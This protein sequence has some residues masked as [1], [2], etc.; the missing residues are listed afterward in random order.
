MSEGFKIGRAQAGD[1]QRE[2]PLCIPETS[3]EELAAVAE[4]LKT[5]WL[6]HGPKNK[7]FERLFAEY[8]GVPYAVSLNSCAS[9]LFLVLKAAQIRG[10]VI[11]PSFTFV[12]SANAVEA[13][14][15]KCVFA[16]VDFE[17]CMLNPAAVAAAVTSR[18]EALMVVHF[19]GQLAD[20]DALTAIA[21]KHKLLLIEDSAEAIGATYK[22][23]KSGAW[24]E[25]CFS[26][27][28]TK[29]IT[30]GEGGMLTTRDRRLADEVRT[31]SGHGIASTTL[32]REKEKMPW[33]RAASVPGYNCRMSNILAAIGC[34]QMRR[35]DG[36][37]AA[38]RRTAA[39][40]DRLLDPEFFHLPVEKPQRLHAYQMYTVKLKTGDRTA[41]LSKL[42]EKGIGATVHFDPAVHEQPY[43]AAQYPQKEGALPV[44]E[45]LARSIVTLPLYPRLTE[46]EAI[47]VAQAAN[48]AA[49][50]EN[51]GAATRCAF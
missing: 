20:M 2:I 35:L 4:V 5:G 13:A 48:A 7:E 29:N 43:Y 21:A 47:F 32:A 36:M 23:K 10:E 9:A 22:G 45:A 12:A 39:L 38:R 49:R 37:N 1:A 40:Y 15:A 42:R 11:L 46:E 6:A 41:F 50:R 33:L 28:P 8:L 30:T 44:T 34:E 16:D 25:G 51:G 3:A 31:Y 18:T 24:G 17:T 26:F 14:G 19:A 27:W